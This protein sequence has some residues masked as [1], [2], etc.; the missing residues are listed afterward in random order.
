MK[1]CKLSLF[2][3]LLAAVSFPAIAQAQVQIDVPFNFLVAGKSLPA[4]N[5]RLVQKFDGSDAAWCICGDRGSVLILTNA[6]NPPLKAH[7]PS[8]VFLHTGDQYSLARFWPSAYA[9]RELVP[10]TNV[11]TTIR[12]EGSKSAENGQYIEIAAK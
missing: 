3:A 6:V 8:M 10:R 11:K 12:A 1:F 9:G 7:R 2:C 5:Y 4:G